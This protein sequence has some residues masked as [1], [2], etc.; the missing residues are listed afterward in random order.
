M[1]LERER[2]AAQ[3]RKLDRR[4]KQ[5]FFDAARDL[6]LWKQRPVK[7][8]ELRI[9][10]SDAVEFVEARTGPATS[11]TATLR[12]GTTVPMTTATTKHLSCGRGG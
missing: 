5:D 8:D 3:A 7:E 6:G 10:F 2:T 11:K 12:T 4:A 9:S 1:R